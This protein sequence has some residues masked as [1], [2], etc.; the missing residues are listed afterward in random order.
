[1]SDEHEYT[2]RGRLELSGVV[3]YVKAGNAVEAKEKAARGEYEEYDVSGAEAIN[4]SLRLNSIE[5][6]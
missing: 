5:D 1:M 4:C 2:F 6:N 3:F